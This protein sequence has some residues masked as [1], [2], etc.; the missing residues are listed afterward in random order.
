MLGARVLAFAHFLDCGI[1]PVAVR[2]P[3]YRLLVSQQVD[4]ERELGRVGDEDAG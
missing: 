4:Q 2:V 3:V 1:E